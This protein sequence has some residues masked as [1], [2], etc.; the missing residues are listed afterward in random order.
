MGTAYGAMA[1]V[2]EWEEAL[3]NNKEKGVFNHSANAIT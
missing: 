1:P 2:G 3:A